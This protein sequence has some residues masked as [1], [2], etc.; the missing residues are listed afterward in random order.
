MNDIV[1]SINNVSDCE[2]DLLTTAKGLS[3]DAALHEECPGTIAEDDVSG[4]KLDL[5]GVRKARHEDI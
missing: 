5:A 4:E 1:S 2:Q 3:P